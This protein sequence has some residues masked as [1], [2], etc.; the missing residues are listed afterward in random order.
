LHNQRLMTI[1]GRQRS[2]L[3]P[4]L[5]VATAGVVLMVFYISAFTSAMRPSELVREIEP[6]TIAP[7]PRIALVDVGRQA[8]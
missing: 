8:A 5:L 2:H 4:D 6:Q 7:A 1:A 3:V